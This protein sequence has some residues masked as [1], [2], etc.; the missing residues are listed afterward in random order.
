[1]IEVILYFGP[2]IVIARVVGRTV[3]LGSQRNGAMLATIDGM[4]LS[5]AGVEREFPDLKGK[6]NWREEAIKRFKEKL[7]T[8]S[9]EDEVANYV[10][11]D[12]RKFGYTPKYKQK[13]GFR[14]ERIK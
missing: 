4:K 6:D 3:Y 11:E 14:P 13:A 2:E 12:L 5:R 8:F 10:I 1:M 9:S 7:K